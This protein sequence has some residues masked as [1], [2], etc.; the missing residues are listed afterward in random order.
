MRYIGQRCINYNNARCGVTQAKSR[1]LL[2]NFEDIGLILKNCVS[3]RWE[4]RFLQPSEESLQEPDQQN[5]LYIIPAEKTS[6]R[7]TNGQVLGDVFFINSMQ[8]L[9]GEPSQ[10]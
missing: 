10:I 5:R 9:E 1:V 4:R 2:L 6:G 8:S 3:G 7:K